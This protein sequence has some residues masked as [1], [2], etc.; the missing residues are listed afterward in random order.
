M[1]LGERIC[2]PNGS[3]R[4]DACPVRELCLARQQGV[5]NELP[6]RNVKKDKRTEKKT[7]L[8]IRSA[9]GR[10]AIR[11]R[12]EKGLLSGM[13][14][15]VNFNGWGAEGD[16]E[17]YLTEQGIRA[18]SIEGLPESKH[19]FTHV[20]WEMTGYFVEALKETDAVLWKTRDEVLS[21]Y[22]IPTAFKAYVKYMKE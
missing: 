14:E 22:A 3:P 21:D 1:E 18:S 15:L 11:K 17:S 9:A 5:E 13:W 20:I 4:C 19:I 16:V 12:S 2:I 10:Y 6:V 7:I 8:L